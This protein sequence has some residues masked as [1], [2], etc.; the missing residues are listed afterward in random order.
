MGVT[1][2]ANTEKS[3]LPRFNM[4]LKCLQMTFHPFAIARY[5]MSDGAVTCP[6]V[7]DI[8]V[9]RL[10]TRRRNFSKLGEETTTIPPAKKI[11]PPLLPHPFL[12]N[13]KY[14]IRSP[15]CRTI[16]CFF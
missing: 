1:P 14:A 5:R 13:A 9:M 15:D 16:A 8:D 3:R 2:F 11:A 4:S 6:T 12:Q 10:L 7:P